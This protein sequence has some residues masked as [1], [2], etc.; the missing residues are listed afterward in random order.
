MAWLFF[1]RKSSLKLFC[2]KW[3]PRGWDS[4]TGPQRE[5]HVIYY[6][7]TPGPV[8]GTS[9]NLLGF[10]GNILS[11]CSLVIFWKPLSDLTETPLRSKNET[12][13]MFFWGVKLILKIHN[14][15]LQTMRVGV[16]R[17]ARIFFWYSF[18]LASMTPHLEWPV[19]TKQASRGNDGSLIWWN[20]LRLCL[21]RIFLA[22]FSFLLCLAFLRSLTKTQKKYDAL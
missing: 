9:V 4:I 13:S 15:N 18:S 19:G 14:M 16:Y 10:L 11:R 3:L 20:F 6:N 8:L 12:I 2:Y 1:R 21:W 5:R 22:H 7:T 17:N